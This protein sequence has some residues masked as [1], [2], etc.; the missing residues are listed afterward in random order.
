MVP[1]FFFN[2]QNREGVLITDYKNIVMRHCFENTFS[3]VLLMSLSITIHDPWHVSFR[4][5]YTHSFLNIF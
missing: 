2:L 1:F 5:L 3:T 4:N